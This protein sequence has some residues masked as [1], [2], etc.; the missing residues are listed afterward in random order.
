M[1]AMNHSRTG[2]ADGACATCARPGWLSQPTAP[3]RAT[4]GLLA[5]PK[6]GAASGFSLIELLVVITILAILMAIV[7]P[8]LISTQPTR[9]LA[10]ASERFGLDVKY[11]Q[12]TASSTGNDVIIGFDFDVNPKNIEDARNSDGTVISSNINGTEFIN[13]GNP[14]AARVATRYYIIEARK[15]WRDE[16]LVGGASAGQPNFQRSD[17]PS[18]LIPFTY[19]DWLDLYDAY[20]NGRLPS[21]PVEPLFP[22]PKASAS[23]AVATSTRSPRRAT[24]IR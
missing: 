24:C 4:R 2:K 14:G 19:L 1:A 20:N 21:P 9:N 5:G 3:G 22:M 13:P 12:Q 11:A 17:Q 18:Y 10:A 8:S 23:R 6:L 16:V 15:R 7:I